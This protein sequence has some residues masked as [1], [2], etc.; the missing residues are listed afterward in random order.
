[1]NTPGLIV[2]NA[3]L[4]NGYSLA[5]LSRLTC[6]SNSVLEQI[7]ANALEELGAEVFVKGHL[8]LIARELGIDGEQLI[9]AYGISRKP[10]PPPEAPAEKRPGVGEIWERLTQ[11][12]FVDFR[13]APLMVL[14]V[15]AIFAVSMVV[16]SLVGGQPATAEGQASFPESKGSS[17]ALEQDVE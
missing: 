4:A 3:R 11:T 8:R 2:K 16:F 6:I 10:V 14:G 1:M 12:R 13:S 9:R 5:D 15:V 17:W 7:E